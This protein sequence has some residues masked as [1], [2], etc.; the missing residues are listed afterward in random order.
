MS[1]SNRQI[2]VYV[3][4]VFFFGLPPQVG[5]LK[6]AHLAYEPWRDYPVKGWWLDNLWS[7]LNI[8][9]DVYLEYVLGSH[10]FHVNPKSE[11]LNPTPQ[12]P[13]IIHEPPSTISKPL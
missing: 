6:V 12:T 3:Y 7:E 5:T 1:V 4:S 9:D 11:A 13:K 10:G 8:T 2:H